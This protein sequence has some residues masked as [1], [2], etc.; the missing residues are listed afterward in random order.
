MGYDFD[1]TGDA[2]ESDSNYNDD[3]DYSF[4]FWVKVPTGHGNA[5]YDRI[6]EVG[7]LSMSSGGIGVEIYDASATEIGA[8]VWTSGSSSSHYIGTGQAFTL[9]EWHLVV[10]STDASGTESKFYFDSA[11]PSTNSSNTRGTGQVRFMMGARNASY[12]QN[13]FEGLLAEAWYAPVIIPASEVT[14]LLNGGYPNN[15]VTSIQN[16][17]PLYDDVSDDV[18][19]D[20]LTVRGDPTATTLDHPDMGGAT[21][22]PWVFLDRFTKGQ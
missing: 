11:T 18:G 16:Y 10:V 1:G 8:A 6:M 2:L 20:T 9:D 22:S 3:D 19:A 7:G 15:V 4:G 5:Q 14:D 17:W 12:N 21:T 13:N